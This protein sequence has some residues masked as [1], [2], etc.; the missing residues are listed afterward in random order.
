MIL[1]MLVFWEPANLSEIIGKNAN[2]K[3]LGLGLKFE[4]LKKAV[5]SQ[6]LA[7]C[8]SFLHTQAV[9]QTKSLS[10]KS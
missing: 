6:K 8:P 10:L 7:S 2:R 1:M 3:T 9:S 4:A 5:M